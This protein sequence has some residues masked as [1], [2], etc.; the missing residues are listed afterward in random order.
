MLTG[1]TTP[2]RVWMWKQGETWRAVHEAQFEHLRRVYRRQWLESFR[3]NADEYIHKYNITKSAQIAQWEHEM[4]SQERQRRETVQVSQGRELLK[5][6]HLDLLREYHE[7]Q[8]FHWYERASERLQY[9]TKI[10]YV[11]PENLSA[12][13]EKELSKYVSGNGPHPLNFAGQMPVLEDE[14]GNVVEVPEGEAKN[15][16]A[17][18]PNSKA[19]IFKPL[20]SDR[21][22]EMIDEF[23]SAQVA[24]MGG[25][26]EGSVTSVLDEETD[27]Q[28]T[29]E[30]EARVAKSMEL[31]NEDAQVNKRAYIDR[32]K[33]GSKAFR[34]VKAGDTSAPPAPS[35]ESQPKKFKKGAALPAE[36]ANASLKENREQKFEKTVSTLSPDMMKAISG[37]KTSDFAQGKLK[38][39]TGKQHKDL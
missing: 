28:T 27:T 37:N 19:T 9:M 23:V 16:F 18:H 13:V 5:Q 21:S 31:S 7:R 1:F 2:Y 34:K 10:N 35:S 8:F 4:E 15:H 39:Q 20:E 12:H 30:E 22:S 25:V 24:E 17:E 38:R 32:G 14:D 26:D 29:V 6:K 33:I 11:T 3:S 36:F